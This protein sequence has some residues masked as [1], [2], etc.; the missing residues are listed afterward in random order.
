MSDYFDAY[1]DYKALGKLIE[2]M[3]PGSEESYEV[4]EVYCDGC[5]RPAVSESRSDKLVLCHSCS[6]DCCCT[7]TL[8]MDGSKYLWPLIGHRHESLRMDA[9]IYKRYDVKAI[10]NDV[11][12]ELLPF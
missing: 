1:F 2:E 3:K 10:A 7:E 5:D 6:P 9:E 8:M 12:A 4:D 11:I